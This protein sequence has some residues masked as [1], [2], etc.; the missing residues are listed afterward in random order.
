MYILKEY[1]AFPSRKKEDGHLIYEF[2]KK[3]KVLT[4]FLWRPQLLSIGTP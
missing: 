1:S 3:N 2:S 4:Y